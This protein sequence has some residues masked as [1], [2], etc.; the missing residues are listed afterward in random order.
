MPVGKPAAL[1]RPSIAR[2]GRAN[3]P[4]VDQEL[5]LNDRLA[6][7]CGGGGAGCRHC[8]GGRRPGLVRLPEQ[9]VAARQAAPQALHMAG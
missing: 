8:L 3:A 9:V 6:A 4:A 1:H 5:L 7:G 2:C